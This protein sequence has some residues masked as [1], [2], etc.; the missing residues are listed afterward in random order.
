MFLD[1]LRDFSKTFSR[2]HIIVIFSDVALTLIKQIKALFD[3][4]QFLFAVSDSYGVFGI[5]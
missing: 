2:L 1:L 3:W 4:N 5:I